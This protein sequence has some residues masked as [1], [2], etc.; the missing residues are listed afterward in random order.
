M[1]RFV[2]AAIA[3]LVSVNLAAAAEGERCKVT[4]PTGTP[5]NVR[6]SPKGK[7][8]GTLANGTF[9]TIVEFKN[10]ANGKPWSRSSTTRPRSRSAGFSASSCP[11][12]DRE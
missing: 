8:I 12:S 5:L 11:A 9:V 1:T 3:L 10:A 7:I 2:M 4:D 6:E